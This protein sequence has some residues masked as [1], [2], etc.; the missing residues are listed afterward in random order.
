MIIARFQLGPDA[1]FA[2]TMLVDMHAPNLL[3]VTMETA[4]DVVWRMRFDS[5]TAAFECCA[6]M[7]PGE[8]AQ[9]ADD[10]EATLTERDPLEGER[11][12]ERVEGLEVFNRHGRAVR[13]TIPTKE[14]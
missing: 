5:I 10:T 11:K 12:V 13:V 7:L 3:F 2:R 4:E 6:E 14:G 9:F 1:D 8:I